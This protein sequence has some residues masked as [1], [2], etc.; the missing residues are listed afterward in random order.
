MFELDLRDIS[1]RPTRSDIAIQLYFVKP[2]SKLSYASYMLQRGR[3]DPRIHVNLFVSLMT[4][5]RII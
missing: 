1:V 4:N 3:R 5:Q 2:E